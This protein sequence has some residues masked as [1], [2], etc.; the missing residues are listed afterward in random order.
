MRA[1][2]LYLSNDWKMG[3]KKFQRLEAGG[4]GWPM[5]GEWQMA[6]GDPSSVPFHSKFASSSFSSSTSSVFIYF[7]FL[8][9]GL[10]GRKMGCRENKGEHAGEMP[11]AIRPKKNAIAD[12]NDG[13]WKVEVER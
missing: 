4:G 11:K 10:P 2:T 8:D 5:V 3:S 1:L 13:V 9:H 6:G 12:F 7:A